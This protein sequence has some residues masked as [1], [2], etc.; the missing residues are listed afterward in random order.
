M[1]TLGDPS[2]AILLATFRPNHE[3]LRTQINS[4]KSQEINNLVIY[5]GDDGSPQQDIDLI[6]LLLSDFNYKK[7]HSNRIGFGQNFLNLLKN[8]QDEDY[9][10][11]LDQDD[12][13]LPGK[14]KLQ[15]GVLGNHTEVPALTHH[16]PLKLKSGQ[17]QSEKNIC[18]NHSIN[19]LILRNCVQGCTA[20]FNR[21]ARNLVLSFDSSKVY[22]H[23]WW[24]AVLISSQ[25]QIF[26]DSRPLVQYR[27]HKANA[28][29][30][31][32]LVSKLRKL[33]Q[34]RIHAT[35]QIAEFINQSRNRLNANLP[36]NADLL[37]DMQSCLVRKRLYSAIIDIRRS[38]NL[39]RDVMR[40]IICVVFSPNKKP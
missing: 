7:Y 31:P 4:L 22:W 38:K 33:K 36:T 34:N 1:N 30:Y 24:V 25:G 28:V 32:S 19:E 20:L 35:R 39:Y 12:V 13:W 17:V 11:F 40:R 37:L 10:A 15:I 5:W 2:I 3:F 14:L 6:E 29:G 23:D 27:I 8:T 18:E 26:K 21:K 16:A 9:Y